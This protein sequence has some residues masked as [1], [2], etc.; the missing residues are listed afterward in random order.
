MS[1]PPDPSS[2]SSAPA[3]VRFMGLGSFES[4]PALT[5]TTTDVQT[6][7]ARPDVQTQFPAAGPNAGF[8]GTNVTGAQR[9]AWLCLY[10]LNVGPGTDQFLGCAT[11][12]LSHRTDQGPPETFGWDRFGPPSG[13]GFVPGPFMH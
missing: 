13:Y 8:S 11:W 12:F 3:T 7:I 10:L 2:D 1:G 4:G 9:P 5:L 6:G